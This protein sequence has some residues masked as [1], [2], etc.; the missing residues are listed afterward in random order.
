MRVLGP[1]DRHR[2]NLVVGQKLDGPLRATL[3]VRDED[4]RLAALAAAADLGRPTRAG[5]R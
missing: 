5:G 3:R 1:F 2:Q 4:H